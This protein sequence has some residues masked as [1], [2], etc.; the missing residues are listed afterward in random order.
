M[1]LK[2]SQVD[3][4]SQKLGGDEHLSATVHCTIVPADSPE[5]AVTV[6]MKQTVGEQYAGPLEIGSP[7]GYKGPLDHTAFG[8]AV[9]AYYRQ[10]VN[11]P[12]SSAGM[13]VRMSGNLFRKQWETTIP[14]PHDG[15]PGW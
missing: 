1:R 5:V 11:V 7:A 6:V 13:N 8:K 10:M 15:A 14:Q 2:F 12:G 3:Q 4:T 9:E